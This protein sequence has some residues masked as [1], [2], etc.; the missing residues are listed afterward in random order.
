MFGSAECGEWH[1]CP[2]ADVGLSRGAWIGGM[3]WCGVLLSVCGGVG[4]LLYEK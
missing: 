1:W 4:W 3:V 2:L